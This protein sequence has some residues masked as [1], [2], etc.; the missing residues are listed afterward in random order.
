MF[1]K[2]YIDEHVIFYDFII[3]QECISMLYEYFIQFCHNKNTVIVFGTHFCAKR[4][5]ILR[6][7]N[8]FCTLLAKILSL[9]YEYTT[10]I[11]KTMFVY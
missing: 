10:I 8:I 5:Q 11:N 2:Y 4:S 9:L 7:V 3:A 1:M 6:P